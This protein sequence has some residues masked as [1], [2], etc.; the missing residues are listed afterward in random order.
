MATGKMQR[1]FKVHRTINV[2]LT[3]YN[4]WLKS[5]VKGGE[6]Q[7]G[8]GSRWVSGKYKMWR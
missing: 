3:Q 2:E 1:S 8:Q 6:E 4:E 7:R 5:K